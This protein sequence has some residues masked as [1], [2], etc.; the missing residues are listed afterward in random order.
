MFAL[1]WTDP[2]GSWLARDRFGKVPLYAARD[3]HGRFR[4]CSERKAWP[5][6]GSF[7]TIQPGTIVALETGAVSRWYQLP[8]KSPRQPGEVRS[9]IRQGVAKRLLADAPVCCLASGGLDSSLILAAAREAA[10]SVIAYTAVMDEDSPDL[11][12]AR[13]VCSWLGVEL[14]EVDVQPPT[15]ALVDQAI[16][17][18]ELPTKAQIEIALLCLPLAEQIAADG[19]K[20]CL[21]GEAADELFAGYGNMK[22]AAHG[23]DDSALI[24]ERRAA[25]AKMS[26]GNF[27]RCNKAFLSHGVECR[28]PFMERALVESAVNWS[29]AESPV[30]KKLLKASAAG[31]LPPSIIRRRK[32]TFQGAAGTSS[33]CASLV[34]DP[35][36]YYRSR[37]CSMFGR[38]LDC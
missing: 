4:W 1:A 13:E 16:Q 19:F 25:L 24:D 34:V 12:A 6:G 9:L 31:V 7:S 33:A 36:R 23:G 17:A 28:L 10:P 29:R 27:V 32:E 21:S 22:L 15:I 38:A 11:A 8:T 3:P 35:A 18:I 2:R 14:R 5:D 20:A 37:C 30:A 26:R